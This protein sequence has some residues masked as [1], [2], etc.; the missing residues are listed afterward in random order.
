MVQIAKE[1]E[2]FKDT[3][4]E[5]DSNCTNMNDQSEYNTYVLFLCQHL[6]SQDCPICIRGMQGCSSNK[7]STNNRQ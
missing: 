4:A 5:L 7:F 6:A 1:P 3:L 2:H